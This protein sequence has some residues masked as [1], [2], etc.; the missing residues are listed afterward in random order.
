[1]KGLLRILMALVVLGGLV[2]AGRSWSDTKAEPQ[3]PRSRVALLNLTKVVKGYEKFKKYSEEVKKSVEPFQAQDKVF[4]DQGEKLAKE[5]QEVKTTPARREQI[6]K[7]LKD[8]QRQ[9]EDNKSEAQKVVTKKQEDQLTTL[10]K[11]VEQATRRYARANDLDL[12]MHYNDAATEEELRSPANLSRKLQAGAAIP[13]YMAA[14]V[15]VSDKIL[16]ALN[17]SYAKDN[18]KK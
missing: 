15:D 4:K 12:V 17:R 10:Y 3:R 14:G 18:T 11:D 16:D 6:E 2:F 1:M 8:L 9:I 13:I 5:A 7:E